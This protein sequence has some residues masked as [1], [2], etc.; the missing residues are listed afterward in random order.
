MEFMTNPMIIRARDLARSLGVAP[1][2]SRVWGRGRYEARFGSEI[3]NSI[4]ERDVVWDVGGNTGYYTEQFAERT[5]PRGRVVAF[6]P[7]PT[8]AQK[9]RALNA[10]HSNVV[11]MEN[12]LGKSREEVRFLLGEDPMGTTS[13]I[14]SGSTDEGAITVSMLTGDSVV[15]T[16]RSLDP[17]LVKIDVEGH[18][19]DVLKGMTRILSTSRLR[20]IFVEVHFGLLRERRESPAA[21]VNLLNSSGYEVKWLDASHL[22]GERKSRSSDQAAPGAVA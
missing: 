12:A 13:R 2:L 10:L 11:V 8:N 9:I 17:H 14:G 21:I 3:L 22:V 1:F 16:D 7:S 5:G 6:E 19:F 15:E 20:A 4:R 18:E